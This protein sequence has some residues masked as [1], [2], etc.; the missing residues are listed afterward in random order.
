MFTCMR[1]MCRR[2]CVT[3]A[4]I[5]SQF[6]LVA[7]AF[8]ND[9]DL[10]VGTFND[11]VQQRTD[12][13]IAFLSQIFGS[14]SGSLHGT[15]GQMLGQLFYQLNRG[16]LIVA[17]I[18]LI[19]T[20][21]TVVLK[22]A[23]EG[24]FMGQNKNVGFVF[25]KIALGIGLLLPNP[26]TG[27]SILQDVM[28]AVVVKG[29]E[30]A[31]VTWSYGLNYIQMG[32]TLYHRPETT[33][34]DNGQVSS[35]VKNILEG[36][37]SGESSVSTASNAS[38]IQKIFSQE[39]CMVQS[40]IYNQSS[41]AT[42]AA[43]PNS[44]NNISVGSGATKAEYQMVEDDNTK[45]FY[46]PGLNNPTNYKPEDAKSSPPYCG[47]ISWSQVNQQNLCAEANVGQGDAAQSLCSVSKNAINMMINTLMPAAY[48]YACTQTSNTAGN[49]G[50]CMGY[51]SESG[52]DLTR[53]NANA[54]YSAV[55]DYI[56]GIL[57]VAQHYSQQGANVAAEFIPQ[58]KQEGW[59]MAG[60]YYW[61]L[62]QVQA[63]YKKVS[64]LGNYVPLVTMNNAGSAKP[65]ETDGKMPVQVSTRALK[66]SGWYVTKAMES[67]SHFA[68]ASNSG[69]TG[70][71]ATVK[72]RTGK[73]ILLLLLG[74]IIG[75]LVRLFMNFNTGGSSLGMGTDPIL[76]LHN[77]GMSCISI[78]GDIFFSL[79]GII[80]TIMAVTIFCQAEVN[81]ADV[82]NQVI[83][84]IKP[85]LLM[86]GIVFLG[87]GVM[88]GYYV[89]LYPFMIFMFGVLSWIIEVLEAMIA[90]PLICLG[91][92]HP[93]T[94]DFLG[95]AEQ[96]LMLFL[97]IFLLPTL[98]VIG[99]IAAMIISYVGLRILLYSF[100]GFLMDLFYYKHPFTGTTNNLIS[101]AN[102]AASNIAFS[103]L[104]SV[105]LIMT[106]L[107]FPLF[108][109]VFT[110][111]VYSMLV[112]IFNA[113][114]RV[115]SYVFYWIGGPQRDGGISQA[116]GTVQTAVYRMGDGY[117]RLNET[118][119]TAMGKTVSGMKQLKDGKGTHTPGGDGNNGGGTG[120]PTS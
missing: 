62:S 83:D 26:A 94:H 91:L 82:A 22:S 58:A 13:S 16:I 64:N 66:D 60:R 70:Y 18:W 39:V 120:S 46:F 61:D 24:S 74:P 2:L 19:Y 28:M 107:A 87:V 14:V 84:W 101:A 23:N 103:Q 112:Y 35:A 63:N 12:S 113:P 77:V 9:P 59:M 110:A 95:R 41:S 51:T 21:I 34:S 90:A 119:V 53:D 55:L 75:D 56:N 114:N 102:Q 29:V 31:D 32:G 7:T 52:D 117:G 43:T 6:F 96:A 1:R 68:Q 33:I 5:I 111:M 30:L 78:A 27:Y 49:S 118:S 81:A 48:R 11:A 115:I 4:L 15:S 38:L 100:S 25:L 93:E 44:G 8:A 17:G 3:V 89:P 65:N 73:S 50:V 109:V 69:D 85:P 42:S 105:G 108:L 76:F 92:T 20:I 97:R 116:L 99:F 88:L 57:P 40:S 106:V 10:H 47:Q 36:S 86:V 104:G 98:M 67:L 37:N 71:G 72:D 54:F 80:A 79:I 45:N